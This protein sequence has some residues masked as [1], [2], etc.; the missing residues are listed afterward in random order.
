MQETTAAPNSN[1]FITLAETVSQTV[2]A[3]RLV[4]YKLAHHPT[5]DPRYWAIVD[6]NQPSTEKRFYLFDTKSETITP[7]FVAHGHG[8]GDAIRE[9]NLLYA[10]VFSNEIG[11]NCSSL[12]IYSC[13]APIVS[14][15]HGNALQI[16]G[17]ESTNSNAKARSVILHKADYVSE[18]FI[19]ENGRLGRSEGC[20][21]V[22]NSV[23]D[24]LVAELKNGS[25]II[26]WKS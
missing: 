24:T 23:V 13:L 4:Q 26:A 3:N 19:A 8:N 17:L 12:G 14:T 5:G 11:S 25:Y 18:T 2:P 1:V 21:A 20:F 10:K 16:D 7:Y 6:F 9:E 15:H 22:E